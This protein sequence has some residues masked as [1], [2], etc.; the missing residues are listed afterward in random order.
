MYNELDKINTCPLDTN[1]LALFYLSA[2]NAHYIYE[3]LMFVCN[4]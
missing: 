1:N 4:I 2:M 3:I